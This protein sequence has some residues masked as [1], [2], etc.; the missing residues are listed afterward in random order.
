M[1]GTYGREETLTQQL[2]QGVCVLQGHDSASNTEPVTNPTAQWETRYDLPSPTPHKYCYK[3][4]Y[5]L[6]PYYHL[7]GQWGDSTSVG[8]MCRCGRGRPPGGENS[9][10][11]S[12]WCSMGVQEVQS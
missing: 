8:G 12:E 11:A 2:Y 10:K 9:R 5:C 6:P 7:R 3:E 4:E 1:N